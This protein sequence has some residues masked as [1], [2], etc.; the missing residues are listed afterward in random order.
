VGKTVTLCHVR[1]CC[2]EAVQDLRYAKGKK[3]VP[4]CEEHATDEVACLFRAGNIPAMYYCHSGWCVAGS[5]TKTGDMK[6]NRRLNTDVP[7]S[8]VYVR[9]MQKKQK[10]RKK[11]KSGKTKSSRKRSRSTEA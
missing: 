8:R 11:K 5:V 4:V 10:K 2:M 9:P 7:S 1:H 6:R 3:K